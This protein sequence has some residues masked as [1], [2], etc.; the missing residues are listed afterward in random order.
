LESNLFT[1]L[2]RIL[3]FKKIANNLRSL[4]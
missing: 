3:K 4:T 2:R 1:I